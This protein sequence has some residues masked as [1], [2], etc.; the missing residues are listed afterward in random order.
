LHTVEEQ[1]QRASRATDRRALRHAVFEVEWMTVLARDI[2]AVEGALGEDFVANRAMVALRPAQVAAVETL[3]RAH[4]EQHPDAPD[5]IAQLALIRQQ[6]LCDA[7]RSHDRTLQRIAQAQGKQIEPLAVEGPEVWMDPQ[8]HRPFLSSL[9]H[10]FRN[11]MDHGIEEPELREAAGKPQAGRIQCRVALEG[12][13]VRLEIEDDGAG[14]DEVALRA[15]ARSRGVNEASLSLCELMCVD[16]LSTRTQATELSG[17]GVGFAAVQQT[18]QALGGQLEVTTQLG[19][20]TRV[21]I[22]WPAP[23]PP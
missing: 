9:V 17:R 14:V 21:V 5:A 16:G 1:L 12:A 2:A 11:A 15:R 10:V 22:R 23:T 7:L 19:R 18:V 6:R 4:L 3:A 8:L 13:R 20:G